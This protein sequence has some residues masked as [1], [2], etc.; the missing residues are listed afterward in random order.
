MRSS[1]FSPSSQVMGDGLD[2]TGPIAFVCLAKEACGGIPGGLLMFESPA[3][4]GNFGKQKPERFAERA[5]QMG[6]GGVDRDDCV[7]IGD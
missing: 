1:G 5:G 3:P 4:I 6:D 2:G 7:Q